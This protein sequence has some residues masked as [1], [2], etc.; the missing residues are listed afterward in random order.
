MPDEI[1]LPPK[2]RIA[3]VEDEPDIAGLVVSHLR[4]EGFVAENYPSGESFFLSLRKRIPDLVLLDLMLP[5]TDGLDICRTLK[6]NEEWSR[7]PVIIVTAKGEETDRIIGLEI[8][9]D[10]YVPKPFSLKELAARIRAV[11]RRTAEK[12]VSKAIDIGGVLSIDPE[13]HEVRCQ[14]APVELTSTEFNILR[15]LASKKGRVFTRDQILDH[16]WGHDKIVL[17]RTVD[18]HVKNL[19]EKLGP[20]SHFI[21]NIRGVG[22]KIEE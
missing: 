18:V 2:N 7:I 20:A 6:K 22:Y 10:D 8:G 1:H 21:K 11:L 3:V 14:G 5:D 9:A 13:K 17:D 4:K 16:L 12:T 19:R 15:L